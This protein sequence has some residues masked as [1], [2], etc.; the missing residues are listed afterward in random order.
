M[1]YINEKPHDKAFWIIDRNQL[2]LCIPI[3]EHLAQ[4]N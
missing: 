1:F 2:L 3:I 4:V